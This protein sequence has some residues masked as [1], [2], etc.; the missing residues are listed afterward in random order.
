MS[1]LMCINTN[2]HVGTLSA[3]VKTTGN[4]QHVKYCYRTH[5][6]NK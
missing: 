1:K 6:V 5:F 3:R 4:P 2:V